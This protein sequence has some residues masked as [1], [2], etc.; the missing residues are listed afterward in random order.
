MASVE[1]QIHALSSIVLT[2][3]FTQVEGKDAQSTKARR[4]VEQVMLIYLDN[5]KLLH[6]GPLS[7]LPMWIRDHLTRDEMRGILRQLVEPIGRVSNNS[8]NFTI[9]NKEGDVMYVLKLQD[10]PL[11]D[12]WMRSQQRVPD[13][14][15]TRIV[16]LG[17]ETIDP[18]VALVFETD[19]QLENAPGGIRWPD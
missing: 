7:L 8:L 18:L 14:V 4:I 13:T 16:A 1:A 5:P 15:S 2:L 9:E 19:W 17:A 11:A 3:A 10:G 12:V 6:H